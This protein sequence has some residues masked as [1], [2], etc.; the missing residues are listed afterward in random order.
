MSRQLTLRRRHLRPSE[1]IAKLKAIPVRKCI[2]CGCTDAK[3]CITEEGPCYW[4]GQDL[5]SNPDCLAKVT[6]SLTGG[7]RALFPQ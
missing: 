4:V 2:V 1:V 6:V 5:C 3:A 7:R